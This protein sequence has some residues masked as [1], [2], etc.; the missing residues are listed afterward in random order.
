[1]SSRHVRRNVWQFQD[2]RSSRKQDRVPVG[3]ADSTLAWSPSN[4]EDEFG[5]GKVAIFGFADRLR[6]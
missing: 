1:M 2:L 6:D 5:R 3:M 4:Y